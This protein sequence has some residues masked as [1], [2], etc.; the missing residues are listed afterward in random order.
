MSLLTPIAFQVFLKFSFYFIDTSPVAIIILHFHYVPGLHNLSAPLPSRQQVQKPCNK[1]EIIFLRMS[2]L[3]QL[4]TRIINVLVYVPVIQWIITCD[5]LMRPNGQ[6]RLPWN[7]KTL[8]E[9]NFVPGT[10]QMHYFHRN[11]NSISKYSI[12]LGSISVI[13]YVHSYSIPIQ[14]HFHVDI[15]QS[16][17]DYF[18]NF[19]TNGND[20]I[21]RWDNLVWLA[22]M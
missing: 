9:H 5:I 10:K 12:S 13:L 1:Q 18:H 15:S 21:V 3:S 6:L 22:K 4:R 2:P 17:S 8:L 19:H 11:T 20:D 14:W 16:S 7:L